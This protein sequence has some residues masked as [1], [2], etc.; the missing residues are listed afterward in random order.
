MRLLQCFTHSH[1]RR[2]AWVVE[3]TGMNLQAEKG[4]TGGFSAVVSRGLNNCQYYS[5]I[6]SQKLYQILQIHL[7]LIFAAIWAPTVQHLGSARFS[8][9]GWTRAFADLLPGCGNKR[10]NTL[11]FAKCLLDV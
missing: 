5:H 11:S 3:V 1:R 7:K 4:L 8:V 10:Y 2:A 6:M 9:E